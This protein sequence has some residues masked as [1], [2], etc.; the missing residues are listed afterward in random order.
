MS[1][2]R[3]ILLSSEAYFITHQN[4]P[5]FLVVI[6]FY[7]MLTFLVDY[8]FRG[9][10]VTQLEVVRWFLSGRDFLS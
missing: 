10:F 2:Y 1:R 5:V 8:S 7:A 6:S 3:A 9:S 4:G